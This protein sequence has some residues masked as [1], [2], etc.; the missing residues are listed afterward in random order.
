MSPSLNIKD[1]IKCYSNILIKDVC[2]QIINE[3]H[4]NFNKALTI[5]DVVNKDKPEYK[6]FLRNCYVKPLSQQ[7]DTIVFN[8]IKEILKL[9]TKDV[10][11]FGTGTSCEDTGYE[12]LLYK[13]SEKGE[14]KEHVD[15]S[16]N[17]PRILSCSLLL[18]DDYEGG[19]F[20][21]FGGKYLVKK[22]ASSAVVFPSNFCFPHAITPVIK[23]NRHA[24]ITWIR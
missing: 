24:I 4:I 16:N 9:Y 22:K 18:K 13:G 23:G 10:P 21:F 12:H 7:F 15:N 20:S 3:P 8:A 6:K 17:S 2:T 19:D 5:D 11:H 14:Y 1:Y